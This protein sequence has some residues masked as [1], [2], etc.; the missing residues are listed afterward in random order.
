MRL[1]TERLWLYPLSDAQMRQ[2]IETE[3][4]PE[5]RQAYGEMLQGCLDEPENRI[6]YAAWHMELKEAPGRIAGDLCF[7]GIAAD[8]MTEIGYGLRPGYC[9]RGY[10]TEALISVTQ[11]ALRQN[12]ITR[13]EAETEQSNTASQKVLSRAGFAPTGT[14]GEEGPRFVYKGEKQN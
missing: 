7:K 2:L 3:Q 6:W 8:G 1:E 4:D 12:G 9:G 13:V 11:W 10:M 5:M 14:A